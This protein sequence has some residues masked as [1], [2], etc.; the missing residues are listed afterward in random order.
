MWSRVFRLLMGV[1]LLGLTAWFWTYVRDG[2]DHVWQKEQ[3]TAAK[4]KPVV[5]IDPTFAADPSIAPAK[6]KVIGPLASAVEHE[7][8]EDPAGTD[9]AAVA[10]P[11]PSTEP[12]AFDHIVR[13][14]SN[15]PRRFHSTFV[16]KSYRYYQ[17]LV[18]P[19]AGSPKLHGSFSA[20]IATPDKSAATAEFLLLDEG[21]FSDFVRGRV[22][23]SVFSS[24]SSVGLVDVTLSPGVL[25]PKK[26]YLVFRSPDKRAR[27]VTA[28]ITASF[29]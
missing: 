11:A 8:Q 26:Y 24:T 28:D 13:P 3:A 12:N 14:S 1:G 21:Q 20:Y 7:Q 22:D 5:L 4:S 2:W 23:D 10:D 19:Q 9:S 15:A 25:E 6:I 29:E 27:V 18:P 16:V 17:L